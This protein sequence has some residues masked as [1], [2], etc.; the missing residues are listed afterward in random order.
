[1]AVELGIERPHR[2][3]YRT[4]ASTTPT[5]IVARQWGQGRRRMG[6]NSGNVRATRRISKKRV[7][8]GAGRRGAGSAVAEAT[9]R[10]RVDSGIF[11]E[12]SDAC[13]GGRGGV[14]GTRRRQ[15]CRV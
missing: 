15:P 4:I 8:S 12:G 7:L 3:A 13:L 1:M 5:T 6:A 11:V 2:A 14:K 9:E 10:G